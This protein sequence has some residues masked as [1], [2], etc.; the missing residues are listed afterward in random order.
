MSATLA[1]LKVQAAERGLA[2]SGTKAQL[3]ERLDMTKHWQ[4]LDDSVYFIDATEGNPPSKS[5]LACYDMDGTLIQPSDPSKEFCE[6]PDDWV[7]REGMKEQVEAKQA[8]G[9]FV[10]IFTNQAR[11]AMRHVTLKR[12]ENVILQLGKCGIFVATARDHYRKPEI[13]MWELANDT[14]GLEPD[15]ENSFFCGDASGLPGSFSDADAGFAKNAGLPYVLPLGY[16]AN[17]SASASA[18]S[19]SSNSIQSSGGLQIAE[20]EPSGEQ[21]L[22]LLVGP[23]ASG[24]STLARERYPN[25]KVASKDIHKTKDLAVA[26]TA[27]LE[28]FSVVI[29]NTNPSVEARAPYLALAKE[30]GVPS[31]IIVMSTSIAEC[32]RRNDLR[33]KR[34]SSIVYNIFKG[35]YQPVTEAEAPGVQA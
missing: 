34:V 11:K 3:Q 17:V 16:C 13:G 26:R 21:E 5:K 19:S 10:L 9:M 14:Y 20:V 30:L 27:L 33:E 24:K 31:R 29:D 15:L 12:L 22:V 18:M 32:K 25:Y 7:F 6:T 23:P 4:N 8:E 2:V 1:Q 35:K 28:G